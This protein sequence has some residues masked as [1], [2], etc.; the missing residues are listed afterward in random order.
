MVRECTTVEIVAVSCAVQ[1]GAGC[2]VE[3]MDANDEPVNRL[4]IGCEK[5]FVFCELGG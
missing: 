4:D 2:A 1:D 3:K 5:R